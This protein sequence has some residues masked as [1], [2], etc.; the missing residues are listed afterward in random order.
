MF[1]FTISNAYAEMIF[2]LNLMQLIDSPTH[3]ADN[4][5][6]VILINT[7]YCQNIVIYPNLPPGP[8]SVHHYMAHNYFFPLHTTV[9]SHQNYLNI[10]T[11]KV[12]HAT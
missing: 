6:D 3:I 12:H 5:L 8:S 7:D 1:S 11:Y 4:I 9:T 10:S 2:D